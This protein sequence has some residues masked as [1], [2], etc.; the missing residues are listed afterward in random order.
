M[1][2][3]S[4]SSKLLQRGQYDLAINKSVKKLLK[5]PTKHKEIDVL[6]RAYKLANEQD[7]SVIDELRI[8]GQPDIWEELFARYSRMRNRQDVVSRLPRELLN[9][10]NYEKIDYNR[11]IADAKNKAAAFYYANGTQLLK[12]GDRMSA[13]KAYDQFLF[14]KKY[15]ANYQ[16]VEMKLQEAL[17]LGT[18]HV[19]FKIQNQARVAL[20]K[21]FED[22]ILKISLSSLNRLWLEFDNSYD[23]NI[24]Y[25]YSIY[26]NLKQIEV[27]PEKVEV[28]KYKDPK[29]VPDGWEYVLDDKGNVRKDSLGNDMKVSKYK[30]INAYITL[31]KMDK[32]AIVRGSLDYVNNRTGQLLKTSPI[33]TEFVFDY[34]SAIYAG[35]ENALSDASKK[36]I[37]NKPMPFPPDLQMIYDTNE[38][39]KRIA[40]EMVKADSPLFVN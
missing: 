12:S 24:Q 35:E 29:M 36:L 18:N 28:E 22:E 27:S 11:E 10:I 8:S 39:I 23:K 17:A 14:I 21:D 16:D 30:E 6:D 20:P 34:K 15:F 13:R 33:T 9:Q 26:L 4:S 31:T 5:N 3:C 19:I 7:K 25:D 1:A 37:K 32:R 38:E 40:F 2:S